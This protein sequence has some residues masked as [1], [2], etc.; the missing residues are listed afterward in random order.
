M[1]ATELRIGNLVYCTQ[2]HVN[3]NI[4]PSDFQIAG[5]FEPIPLTEEILLKCGAKLNNYLWHEIKIKPFGNI[6]VE[7]DNYKVIA[8]LVQE[9]GYTLAYPPLDYVHQL[10]NLYFCLT[11]EELTIE[12]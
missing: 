11:G 2:D 3:I 8:E 10:Q 1:N 7:I 6:V 12:L 4:T 9:R 5:Q